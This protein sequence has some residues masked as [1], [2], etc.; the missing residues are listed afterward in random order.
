MKLFDW[1]VF[2][3]VLVVSW[4]SADVTCIDIDIDWRRAVLVE[5]LN[6]REEQPGRLLLCGSEN[7]KRTRTTSKLLFEPPRRRKKPVISQNN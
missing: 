1:R 7:Q 2:I 4:T 5:T 6:H 3:E